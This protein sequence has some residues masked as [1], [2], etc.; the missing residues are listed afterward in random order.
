MAK[1]EWIVNSKYITKEELYEYYKENEEDP[2]DYDI[3][4]F[5][6]VEISVVRE[7]NEHGIKSYGWN[8]MAKIILFDGSQEYNKEDIEWCKK[9]AK[10]IC[11]A[12][13]KKGL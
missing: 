4:E 2:N 12:L 5:N 11:K 3:K 10:T 1:A 6:E 8:D 7:N 13:N 9:V